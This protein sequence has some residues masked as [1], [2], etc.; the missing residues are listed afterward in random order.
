MSSVLGLSRLVCLPLQISRMFSCKLPFSRIFPTNHFN[1]IHGFLRKNTFVLIDND[2]TMTEPI[3]TAG[4]DQ[5]FHWRI[6]FYQTAPKNLPIY[7][8][9]VR[10]FSMEFVVAE[11]IV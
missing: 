7:G 5:W 9:D 3:Q 10:C 11:C 1:E 4:S 8:R 6:Q 2:N